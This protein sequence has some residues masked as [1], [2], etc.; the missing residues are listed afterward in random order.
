M[1]RELLQSLYRYCLCLT[2]NNAQ[3]EDLLQTAIE[4]WL[5][6]SSR[7]IQLRAYLRKVIR[8]QFIDDCRRLKCVD[9]E[10]LD[11]NAPALLDETCLEEI[12]IQHNLIGHLFE[13]LNPAEREVLYLWAVEGYSAAEIAIEIQQ[14]RGTILSRLHRIKLKTAD[15]A[16]DASAQNIGG[17]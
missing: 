12:E 15:L 17:Q 8:N 4:S 16:L 3:A 2:A 1:D 9:F 5:K 11:D 7:P 13:L 10:P 6:A 14:P